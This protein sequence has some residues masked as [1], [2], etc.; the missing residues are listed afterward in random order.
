MH[1]LFTSAIPRM[2][3]TLLVCFLLLAIVQS[4][5]Q[6]SAPVFGKQSFISGYSKTLGGETIGY[7]SIYPD[8]VKDAL[9]TRCTDG[10]KTIEWETA[11]APA[12]VNEP[13]VYFT[14]IAAHS[15]GT[16][17]GT[18]NF[19]LYI[20]DKPAL[21]F[22]TYANNYPPYWTFGGNDSTRLVFE[23]KKQDGAKDAHGIVYMRVPASKCEVGKPL[24]LKIVGQQQNSTD[25]YMTFQYAFEEKASVEALPFLLRNKTGVKQQPL[26]FSVLHFGEPQT[27]NIEINGKVQPAITVQHGMNSFEI[28]V[29]AVSKPTNI[30]IKA[31]IS[32]LLKLDENITIQPVIPRNIYLIPHSHTDIGY[33]HIQ[34]DVAKIHTAN[35]RA[36]LRTIERT[37]NYPDDSKFVWNIESMWAVEN[38]LNEATPDERSA[39]FA[40]VKNNQVALS[41]FYA[42]VLTGLSTP[43]EMKWITDYGVLLRNQ[44][45]VKVET[46]MMS[47]IPGISWSMVTALAQQGIRYFSNGPNYMEPLPDAGDRVGHII[48]ALGDKPFWW[49]SPT[50]KDSILLWTGGKGYSSWH[51]FTSATVRERG[52]RKIAAYMNELAAKKYPY[53]MVQWRYN[54]VSDNGPLDSMASDF[55]KQWNEQ[56]ESPRLILSTVN[57]LF[58]VF[59]KKYG[60][61]IPSLAGDITP[62][63]EDGAYSTAAEEGENRVLS[64]KIIQLEQVAKE[65]HQPLDANMLYRA[66]RDIVMFHEHTW[67]SYNSIS[68]PDNP[69]AIHQWNY[70]KGFLDSA[71]FYVSQLEASLREKNAQGNSISIINTLPWKRSGYVEIPMQPKGFSGSLVGADGRSITYQ[72]LNNGNAAFSSSNIPA[73]KMDVI[74]MSDKK[75]AA[76]PAFTSS[77]TYATHPQTGAINSLK[78][79]GKEWVDSKSTF[80]GL[81]Q[82]IYVKGM[83]PDSFYLSKAKNTVWIDNGPVTKTQRITATLE[84][85]NEVVYEISQLSG[86]GDLHLKVTIDKKAIRDKE[87]VHI[88]FP[89]AFAKPTVRVGIGDTCITPEKGQ[90]YGANKDFFCVERWIDVSDENSGVTISSPQGALFEIGSMINELHTNGDYKK[91]K[92]EASS[93]STIFLYA[94]N[95]YW[96]TNY[97]ADQGGKV[98]FD[99]TL[100]FHKGFNLKAAKEFGMEVTQPLWVQ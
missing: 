2:K 75:S 80:T 18:R 69:F 13:Y 1:S 28:P 26:Q 7:F 68:D 43:E 52:A 51:G 42:N 54:I 38:F 88:A 36:A 90:L 58:E 84:G 29:D 73:N 37:K 96:H 85:A 46:V 71:A 8:Y 87:S 45:K 60:K 27:M 65:L 66:K 34:E 14:W 24:R 10:K 67:G 3:S 25:W 77:L 11:P 4:N 35:I 61:S 99:F 48:R 39:F 81:G 20:N 19:D 59:E 100:R 55:V 92:D 98:S 44:E 57:N 78:V 16:S 89:F 41:G 94:M 12:K 50:G 30:R 56:Y 82:A 63:W 64:E 86:S 79:D 21:T 49:K 74:K 83:N 9:L 53:D 22:S 70:K 93:S 47:D 97:K 15:T 17:K 95:N 40:A 5:A 33:S 31:S 91:W 72:T 76:N 62:Y 23:L 6:V 32:N